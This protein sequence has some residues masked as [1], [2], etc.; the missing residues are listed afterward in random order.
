M[1]NNILKIY[2][3]FIQNAHVTGCPVFSL[4]VLP[5]F[6]CGEDRRAFEQFWPLLAELPYP[7]QAE[8]PT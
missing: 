7:Q 2:S 6:L 1:T 4:S 5:L 3:M 8:T